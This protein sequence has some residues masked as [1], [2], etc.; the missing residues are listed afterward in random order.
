LCEA[1]PID[2]D[3][4]YE[5]KSLCANE[6]GFSLHAA[7]RCRAN[8]RLKLERLCR[9]IARPA[10]A[11][12]RVKINGKGQM[13]L[14]LKDAVARGTTHHGMSPLESMQRLAEL[15]PRPRLHLVRFGGRITWLREMSVPLLRA[16]RT[17]TE[18][19]VALQGS[20]ASGKQ[21]KGIDRNRLPRAARAW[22]TQL[23]PA[24]SPALR[25]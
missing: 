16:R 3:R 4:D 9:C 8:E 5:R 23:R 20:A 12:D 17:G 10:L 21:T 15:V 14:K 24:S 19:E 13:E 6:Q 25:R 11:N 2:T 22:P 7:V 18:S 1:M